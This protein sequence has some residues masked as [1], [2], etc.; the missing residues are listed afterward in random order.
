MFLLILTV[1]VLAVIWVIP[2]LIWSMLHPELRWNWSRIDTS[3]ARFGG[4]FLWGTASAAYQVEG[5]CENNNW[6]RWEEQAGPDG[7]PRIRGG[8]KAGDACDHWNRYEEDILLMKE[9]GVGAYRF[10]V[11]WSKLEPRRGE[12]NH[13]AFKHYDEIIDA[14]LAEGIEPVVTLHHFTHPLWFQDLGAFEK[15]ENLDLFVKFCVRVF[16]NYQDRVKKWCT[17]NEPG[18]FATMGYYLGDFPPGVRDL[19]LAAHV[20]RNLLLAH[21]KVCESLKALPGGDK[22]EI[23]LVK[24]IF[25]FD[26]YRRWFL[27]DWISARL[28]DRVYNR[29]ILDYLATGVFRLKIPG[30]VNYE[31]SDPVVKGAGDFLGLNYYSH[32]NIRFV[33]NPGEPITWKIRPSETNTDM[34]YAIYP[35]GFFRA[36]NDAAKLGFPVFITENGIA[37][38]RDDRRALF[39][40]RYLYAMSRA[41]EAGADVRGYFYWSLMDNFE[42]AEGYDQKF[43]LYAFNQETRE[44]TLREGSKVFIDM[45]KRGTG[46]TPHSN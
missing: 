7:K 25:Q 41:M 44:R 26:P 20:M 15:E 38:S 35:E 34:P 40:G 46:A 13:D 45:V 29:A 22:A 43:G 6:S 2:C 9:L 21:G 42:W 19:D 36:I 4:A 17:I 10:S 3:N 33:F 31:K 32:A 30:L 5:G 12:F 18:V 8:Q 27:P 37:D 16:T 28:L 39:I 1:S 24:N 23:G 14:L 11:E